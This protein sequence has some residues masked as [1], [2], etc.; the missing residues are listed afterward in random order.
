MLTFIGLS[1]VFLSVSLPLLL[2]GQ[3]IAASWS[4]QAVAMLWLASR[5]RSH[6]LQTIS[7]VLYCIAM[8]RFTAV[9]L[10]AEFGSGVTM[11]SVSDSLLQMLRRALSFGIPVGCLFLGSQLLNRR[12][13]ESTPEDTLERRNDIPTAFNESSAA[14]LLQLT[15]FFAAIFWLTLEF[16][17]TLGII[18]P[19]ARM[20]MITMLWLGFAVCLV[21]KITRNFSEISQALLALLVGALLLKIA[22]F[23]VRAWN[24][25]GLTW[26]GPWNPVHATFRM[27]DFG[28]LAVFLAWAS[29]RFSAES[30]TRLPGSQ[31]T[32][33]ALG[34]A[35][36]A[37]L[38]V[39]FTLEV[40]T[41]LGLHLPGL[42]AGGVSIL[43]SLFAL[44]MLLSGIRSNQRHQRY[45]GLTLFTIVAC[46]VFFSDLASL[47][48]FYRIIAF[49]VLGL[50][51][52][53][54]S[55]LYLRARQTFVTGNDGKPSND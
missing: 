44:G 32:G 31:S 16:N 36:V 24:L 46:K 17:R 23:D 1:S 26:S 55:F 34:F 14:G 21:Q 22:A 11:L 43:W 18:L 27:L 3:W 12:T 29:R 42:R 15:V 38:F 2:S 45:V 40:N 28:M 35:S 30:E 33:V 5:I 50:M 53:G 25:T 49:I 20:T 8:F 10:P 7:I 41:F 19:A 39:W 6:F 52:T 9:D 13:V 47:D 37:A 51:V 48:Q 54:G 4:L